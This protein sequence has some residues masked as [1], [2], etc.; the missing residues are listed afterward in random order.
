VVDPGN[1]DGGASDI[2]PTRRILV[3][4]DIFTFAIDI[5]MFDPAFGCNAI[6]KLNSKSIWSPDKRRG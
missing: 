5:G 4:I 3:E 1:P 6:P 2:D